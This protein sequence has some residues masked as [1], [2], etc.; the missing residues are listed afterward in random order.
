MHLQQTIMNIK[1]KIKLLD[2]V[3]GNGK[4]AEKDDRVIY[5][6]RAFLSKGDEINVNFLDPSVHW[7][8]ELLTHDDKGELINFTCSIGNREAYAAVEHTLIGMKEGGYRKIKSPP[9]LAFQGVGIFD[10]APKN[11]L[12]I[13]EIWLRELQ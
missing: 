10:K 6:L 7:P 2:E 8:E 3:E 11:A 4:S 5:N 12:I 9:N 1:T 13:F